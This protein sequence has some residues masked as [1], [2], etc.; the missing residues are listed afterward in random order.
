MPR[1]PARP[2]PGRGP[3]RSAVPRDPGLLRHR[4][5]DG[6]RGAGSVDP[7]RLGQDG[8][9]RLL[10]ASVER[11]RASVHVCLHLAFGF[12]SDRMAI[13]HFGSF[14]RLRSSL[15][16]NDFLQLELVDPTRRSPAYSQLHLLRAAY[17]RSTPAP[18]RA[19]CPRAALLSLRKT[20][21]ADSLV[22]S[23]NFFPVALYTVAVAHE[24][25]DGQ[26]SSTSQAILGHGQGVRL[27][28]VAQEPEKG[29]H[30]GTRRT[31]Q[32]LGQEVRGRVR[33]N[34]S[35]ATQTDTDSVPPL[36]QDGPTKVRSHLG[37]SLFKRRN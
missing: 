24:Y 28:A 34:T 10:S 31:R 11:A 21:D 33:M 32:G 9:S 15:T 22:S 1:R 2:D 29:H 27:E 6:A 12:F 17:S 4:G 3:R 8:A 30:Q 37:R 18:P 35:R 36:Q 13:L 23:S 14:P 5:G 26:P 25:Q 7:R 16:R 20:P 19:R